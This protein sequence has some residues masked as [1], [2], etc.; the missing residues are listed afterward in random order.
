MRPVILVRVPHKGKGNASACIINSIDE[1]P[2]DTHGLLMC[3]FI[4]QDDFAEFLKSTLPCVVPT[5]LRV[6]LIA[7]LVREKAIELGWLEVPDES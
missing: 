7:A 3:H 1:I 2:D 6:A 4:V 5:R